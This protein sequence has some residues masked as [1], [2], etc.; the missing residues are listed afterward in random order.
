MLDNIREWISDNLRYIL[1]GLSGILLLVIAFFA[2]RLITSFGS[3]KKEAKETEQVTE[4]QED[5]Q[6]EQS[7]EN[8][9][10]KND[11]AV[12]DLMT[13]YYT[14]RADKDFDALAEMCETFDDTN[15]SKIEAEDSAIESYS[16]FMTYSKAGLTDGSYVVYV[17]FD[18]KLKDIDTMSPSLHDMY[19]I[20]NEAGNLIIADYADDAEVES[21]M[22]QMRTDSDVQAL[23]ADVDKSMEE[24]M[25]EDPALKS[26]IESISS[27]SG[28]QNG[29]SNDE[30]DTGED[31][32]TD[33][34]STG[35]MQATTSV[36]V[37]GTA[38]ADGTLYGVL[39][40]G[41]TVTV[42]ENLDSGW[43]KVQY[44]TADG[45]TIEGYVMTQ[46]LGAVQ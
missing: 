44:S 38:S 20:T 17:Y 46:Y 32:G 31:G 11:A 9:L 28:S 26:F 37:R 8:K 35:T 6:T 39:T 3:G 43:S 40:P 2:V 16:N 18:V 25:N 24:K 33:S 14:A 13:R 12:L 30:G 42:L 27:G 7:S 21:Y 34:A 5:V 19:L 45:T 23:I 4:Q 29:G 41:M 22:Q 10:T 15:R 1:L 36:N